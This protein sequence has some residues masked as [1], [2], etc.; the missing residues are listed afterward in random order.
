MQIIRKNFFISCFGSLQRIFIRKL[1][2]KIIILLNYQKWKIIKTIFKQRE[3]SLAFNSCEYA[4]AFCLN[5][6]DFDCK[7]IF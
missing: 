2:K 7:L 1:I 4:V 3:M 6:K 5:L